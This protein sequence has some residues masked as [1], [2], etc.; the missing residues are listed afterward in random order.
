MTSREEGERAR[1]NNCVINW[2]LSSVEI[3]GIWVGV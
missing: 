3:V 1:K 2:N